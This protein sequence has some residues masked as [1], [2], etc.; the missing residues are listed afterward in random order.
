MDPGRFCHAWVGPGYSVTT[1]SFWNLFPFT[2]PSPTWLP[3]AKPVFSQMQR[4]QQ[5]YTTSFIISAKAALSIQSV[6]SRLWI[7]VLTHGLNGKIFIW[8]FCLL[9][10]LLLTLGNTQGQERSQPG[11]VWPL[12]GLIIFHTSPALADATPDLPFVP[13]WMKV[14]GSVI[15][16]R[17]QNS[18]LSRWRWN[19]LPGGHSWGFYLPFSKYPAAALFHFA[20][21]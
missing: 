16:L 12:P 8:C 3:Q 18:L 4:I 19:W 11:S 14:W 9:F 13:L 5:M 7:S 2:P 10:L 17:H 15:S 20:W 21:K 1:C 6:L